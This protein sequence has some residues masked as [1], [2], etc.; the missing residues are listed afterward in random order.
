MKIS[1]EFEVKLEPMETFAQGVDGVNLG[2]MS[3]DKEF[4]G[5]LSA[6]S[7]GEM[8]S[9]VTAVKGSAGYVA[10]EQVVGTLGGKKGSFVLQHYGIMANGSDSLILEVVPNSGSD[11][12]QGL[13]G[14]MNIRIEEGQHY[15]DF[16]YDF[17]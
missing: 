16:E 10:I 2:R 14:K 5:E 15:Y 3:I 1:G 12:L 8:L 9:A 4:K 11:E 6:H 7:K 17:V 13:A